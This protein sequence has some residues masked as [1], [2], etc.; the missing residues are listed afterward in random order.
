MLVYCDS[1]GALI[2]KHCS[3]QNSS[4]C[5][6]NLEGELDCIGTG[7]D[8]SGGHDPHCDGT[9]MVGCRGGKVVRIDCQEVIPDTTCHDLN[10]DFWGLMCVPEQDCPSDFTEETCQ[11]GVI[12]FC[13]MGEVTTLDCRAY[14][15]SGCR[16]EGTAAACTP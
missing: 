5:G 9:V 16:T 11:D 1:S 2:E 12:T 3:R 10:D 13:W 4:E 8:C 14:G 15:L 7:E 6:T